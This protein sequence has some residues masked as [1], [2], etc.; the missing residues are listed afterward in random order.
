MFTRVLSCRRPLFALNYDTTTDVFSAN[1]PAVLL[2]KMCSSEN[3][4]VTS[5]VRAVVKLKCGELGIYRNSNTAS[6]GLKITPSI[7]EM[8]ANAQRDDRPAEYRWRPCS[9]PQFGCAVTL[10]RRE[11]R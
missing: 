2:D 1:S 9:T 10:P 6:V 5:K 8:W 3:C 4:A 7:K 11:T